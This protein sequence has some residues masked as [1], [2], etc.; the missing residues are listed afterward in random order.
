MKLDILAFAAHPDDVELSCAGTIIAE[1]EKGK[2]A[3]I[4]DL[5]QGELGTRGSVEQRF[6]EAAA[7]AK[8]LG[9][10][11]RENLNLGDGTFKNSFTEQKA[12]ITA[13]RKYTP[14][15][16]LAN[17]I[18]DRHPDHGKA[19]ELLKD[20]CFLSG[21]KKIKT[22][23]NGEEQEAWRPRLLL[24]YIQSQWINPDVVI[25]ISHTFD[26]KME[27]I[28]AYSTQFYNP[29][30]HEPETFISSPH[31]IELLKARAIEMG[32]LQGFTYAEGFTMAYPPGVKS[33]NDIS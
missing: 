9:L 8:I 11:A 7:A 15:I 33:L 27:S 17:A 31:F 20:A 12:V 3:G 29:N 30:S 25:D 5:T 23:L 24:H 14:D 1:V 4:I 21:L 16:V 2:T 10:S 13:I 22:K 6:K 18:T 26:K 19:A 28:R 32:N